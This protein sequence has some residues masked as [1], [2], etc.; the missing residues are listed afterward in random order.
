MIVFNLTMIKIWFILSTKNFR[1]YSW[2]FEFAYLITF[3]LTISRNL[4]TELAFKW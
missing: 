1:D 2:N 4:F 3:G